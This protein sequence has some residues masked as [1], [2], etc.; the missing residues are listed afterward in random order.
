[1]DSNGQLGENEREGQKGRPKARQGEPR[2]QFPYVLVPRGQIVFGVV[3]SKYHFLEAVI[4]TVEKHLPYTLD[5]Q[6]LK[7]QSFVYQALNF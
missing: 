3:F 1:M 6:N 7:V 4:F 5:T 2:K